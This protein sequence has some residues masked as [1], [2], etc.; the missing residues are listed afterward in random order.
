[1]CTASNRTAIK[2]F[3]P[4]QFAEGIRVVVFT[5]DQHLFKHPHVFKSQQ[6]V[7]AFLIKLYDKGTIQEDLWENLSDHEMSEVTQL[8][9]HML[10]SIQ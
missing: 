2:G 10:T 4:A 9:S 6:E 3:L 7:S 8:M 1:M 5:H